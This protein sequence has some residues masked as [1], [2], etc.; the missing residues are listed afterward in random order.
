MAKDY[1]KRV[2][3]T[4]RKSK[5]KRWRRELVIVPLLFACLAGYGL[6]KQRDVLFFAENSWFA[7]VR[8][9]AHKAQPAKSTQLAKTKAVT[10]APQ[11]P[12]VHFDFYSELP[13]MQVTVPDVSSDTVVTRVTKVMTKTPLPAKAE[14]A[15]TVQF[16]V[17]NDEVGAD[18]LRL[19]LLLSGVEAE[20]IKFKI[21]SGEMFRVQR[22]PFV[23]QAEAKKL[24]QQLQKK[25]IMGVLK[26]A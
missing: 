12:T 13:N 3:T 9:L 24:Q 20:V 19:S 16:G 11:E 6:F 10:Q 21:E 17:F 25:G 2:F 23:N 15:Y 22:G 18:Q 4:T 1:A 7:H 5:K 14:L 26:K 8:M